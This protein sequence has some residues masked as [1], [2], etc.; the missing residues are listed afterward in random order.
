[1]TLDCRMSAWSSMPTGTYRGTGTRTRAGRMLWRLRLRT[2]YEVKLSHEACAEA[3]WRRKNN[4]LTLA[5]AFCSNRQMTE[6]E[7]RAVAENLL[8]AL[9]FFGHAR[10]G[11]EIWDLPGV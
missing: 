8:L 6:P 3:D 2:G 5:A 4:R 9:R 10:K 7:I 1:M 11:G